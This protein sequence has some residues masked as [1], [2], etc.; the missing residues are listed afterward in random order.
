LYDGKKKKPV[1]DRIYKRGKKYCLNKNYTSKDTYYLLDGLFVQP[2]NN[3]YMSDRWNDYADNE[4][5]RDIY[6]AGQMKS[7]PLIAMA[8]FNNNDHF[9]WCAKRTYEM[10]H[11]LAINLIKNET[12]K[13]GTNSNC[14]QSETSMSILRTA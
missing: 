10:I 1:G 11:E 14:Y 12:V 4:V 5:R 9:G 6:F 8:L 2:L 13:K 7:N 3:K